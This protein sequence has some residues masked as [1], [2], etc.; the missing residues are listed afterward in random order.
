MATTRLPLSWAVN[1]FRELL[2]GHCVALEGSVPVT[3]HAG[4]GGGCTHRHV[5]PDVA[6]PCSFGVPYILP[7]HLCRFSRSSNFRDMK[8]RNQIVVPFVAVAS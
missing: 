2:P 8:I 5:M 6:A 1:F 3:H 7:G 4:H